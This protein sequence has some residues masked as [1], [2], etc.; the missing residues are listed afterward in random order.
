M[1][2][3]HNIIRLHVVSVCY[4]VIIF[5]TRDFFYHSIW[6]LFLGVHVYVVIKT[7]IV[8]LLQGSGSS[9]G[10]ISKSAFKMLQSQFLNSS[11][12]PSSTQ[13]DRISQTSDELVSSI[14]WSFDLNRLIHQLVFKFDSL[15]ALIFQST[16]AGNGLGELYQGH[17]KHTQLNQV[18][19]VT[20]PLIECLDLDIFKFSLGSETCICTVGKQ[21]K[22]QSQWY[23]GH[24][25]KLFCFTPLNLWA[26][27][28]WL[29]VGSF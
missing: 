4:Y 6:S 5:Q 23:W 14:S 26:H 21:N 29:I 9:V 17:R 16:L 7:I 1:N 12:V 15:V 24:V 27:Q 25:I 3:N 19:W 18:L 20:G 22:T 2:T 11:Q 28:N 8:S 13:P 10:G